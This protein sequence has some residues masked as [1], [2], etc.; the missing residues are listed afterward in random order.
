MFNRIFTFSVL[1]LFSALTLFTACQQDE[2]LLVEDFTSNDQ[3]LFDG[4]DR[5]GQKGPQG[6]GHMGGRDG[7]FAPERC[8][9]LIFPVT[10][11]YP[12]GTTKEI[13]SKEDYATALA[14]WKKANPRSK[15]HPEIAFPFEISLADGTVLT[16][17][18]QDE[19]KDVLDDCRPNGH[20]ELNPCYQI[21]FPVTVVFPDSTT[22]VA[23]SQTEFANL[24][25]AWRTNNPDTEGRPSIAFPYSIELSDGSTVVINSMDDIREQNHA[26]RENRPHAPQCFTEVYP[27]T[28]VFP[29]STEQVVNDRTAFLDAARA[30]RTANPGV[31]GRPTIKFPFSVE[32]N[33]GT[34]QTVNSKDDLLAILKS[35]RG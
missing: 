19:L 27:L 20:A 25:H 13:A 23:N 32:R 3:I 22:A 15:Q 9:D 26:C 17:E 7:A 4:C 8:F 31:K 24:V 10:L 11:Q 30:W 33:D 34:V 1:T 29:D 18:T 35:C 6:P 5:G 21:V 28:V 2:S 14:A 12:N 16:I